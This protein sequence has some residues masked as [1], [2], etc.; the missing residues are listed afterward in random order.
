MIRAA[1]AACVLTVSAAAQTRVAAVGPAG[2]A[3]FRAAVPAPPAA[4]PLPTGAR[5]VAA[6]GAAL[7]APAPAPSAAF[8]SALRAPLAPAATA[9]GPASPG[10][11]AAAAIPE[12]EPARAGPAPA[13]LVA[14]P[15]A[16]ARSLSAPRSELAAAAR[17]L[18]EEKTVDR[19]RLDALFDGA[20][21][22][23]SDGV[24][25]PPAGGSAS[26]GRLDRASPS[27]APAGR[28]VP[29]PAQAAVLKK[30]GI[31]V[32]GWIAAAAA[33]GAGIHHFL[34]GRAFGE[35]LTTYVIEWSM[36]L[37][38]LVVI[39]SAL[40]AVP[41]VQ[42]ARALRWGLIGTIAARLAMVAGGVGL[43]AAAH[44]VFAAFG[45]FLLAT[46]LKMASPKLDVIGRTF[47]GLKKLLPRGAG[48]LGTKLSSLLPARLRTPLALGIASVI[49][50]GVVF[51][52]DSVPASLAISKSWF[53]IFSANAFSVM[54]LGALF[55]VI[56]WMNQR[57]KRL[58]MGVAA[59][60][61]FV[62]GKMLLESLFGIALGS[63][64]SLAAIA[65]LLG[66]SVIWSLAARR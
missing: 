66:G 52:L 27:G 16:E 63:G 46:A 30:A 48:R 3:G 12:V 18:G 39:S 11:A 29:A 19:T 43:V 59:V 50:Y 36:S 2:E 7:S 23:A 49:G 37:D 34:G 6:M 53:V 33:F 54:G 64:V 40:L 14:A 17:E 10:P 55:S 60:L 28:P 45:V 13:T 61:A 1:L 20:R 41:E 47:G 57:F 51:A 15:G 65:A 24:E 26:R 38:N 35:Y 5:P 22:A 31:Q 25:P 44:W 32:G 56:A 62:G 42:R 4:L 9:A 21:A 8:A 58:P